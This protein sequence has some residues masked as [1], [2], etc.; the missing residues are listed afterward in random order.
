MESQIETKSPSKSQKRT[1]SKRSRTGCR[2]CRARR[3]KCDE[4][5]GACS[6][7]TSTG[8]TCAYDM[9]R[10]PPGGG[11]KRNTTK[12]VILSAPNSASATI[13][14]AIA[15]K[16]QWTVTSDE[17]R[18]LSFFQHR[19]VPQLVGYF[20][21]PL[22]RELIL[23]LSCT[24]PAVYHAVVALGAVNQANEMAGRTPR[25]GQQQHL[26]RNAWYGFALEQSSRSFALIHKRR[27]SHDP[28]LQEVILVCCLLFIICE[29]LRGNVTEATC[30][31]QGGLRILH[32]MNIERGSSGLELSCG[33]VDEC[34]VE[35]FMNFQEGSIYHGLKEPLRFDSE[36][37]YDRPYEAYLQPF[38]SL[39]YAR[40]A[41]R[42][43]QH[44]GFELIATCMSASEADIASN[45]ATIHLQQ[46]RLIALLTRY[47]QALD[48]FC[49]RTFGT[50]SFTC[51][52][53]AASRDAAR[54]KDFREV[55]LTRL[56]C[57]AL[58]LGL[59]TATYSKQ[60]PPMPDRHLCERRSLLAAAQTVMR[61]FDG[62]DR[63]PAFAPSST[64]VAAVYIAAHVCPDHAFYCLASDLLHSWSAEEGFMSSTRNAK[65]LDE[66]LKLYLSQ[67]WRSAA[68]LPD[69]VTFSTDATGCQV[70][71]HLAYRADGVEKR[72]S[73]VLERDES[74]VAELRAIDNSQDWVCSRALGLLERRSYL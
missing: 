4:S 5:P 10:L 62:P 49:L 60:Q 37:V 12:I 6:N 35:S 8:R 27:T 38:Q 11:R 69:G 34:V 67:M 13:R 20:D 56:T 65:I 48:D 24:E 54:R 47:L 22:W 17:S 57:L 42:P 36:F 51:P 1:F 58:L 7:C 15:A 26:L 30:H 71:A 72:R 50:T 41:F 46:H 74:L 73:M 55:E 43:L 3:V 18:C 39:S 45:Y 29:L 68:P 40:R 66:S 70:T 14:A 19:S 23:R 44:T 64:V 53:M 25:P 21:S 63:R 52:V 31:L 33:G 28:Q 16:F 59:K 32:S 9:Q 2:T 61:K